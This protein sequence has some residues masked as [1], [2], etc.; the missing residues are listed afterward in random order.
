MELW[1]I[2]TIAA[3]FLQNL[4]T[5][6]QKHLQSALSTT[7][8][9]FARFGF[10][11]PFALIYLTVL[12][13]VFGKPL[14]APNSHMMVFAA[15]GGTA[16]I[17]ATFTL[18]HL[19]S[20]RN[21]AVGNAFAKTEPIQAALFSVIILG[22]S[23]SAWA[24]I[25]LIFGLFGVSVI[26]VA[27]TEL[28][29]NSFASGMTGPVARIGILSG[30]LFGVSA[31]CYR[32]ASLALGDGDFV[33]RAGLTLAFTTGFQT[34]LMLAYMRW[35]EQGQIVATLKAWPA[36]LAAGIA[37]ATASACWFTAMTIQNAAYVRALGQIELVFTLVA[38]HFVFKE[39]SNRRELIGILL[40][41]ACILLL[42]LKG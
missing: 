25:A 19:F 23:V 40:I 22:E 37:G 8:A 6:F 38:S 42:L 7:G 31:V 29:I 10:G 13:V 26:S 5:A 4:R 2:I 16:Q 34:L 20:R 41:T 27:R 11:F 1:V 14:P 33:I 3:A 32:A 15:I 30:A 28:T 12:V 35:R 39:R 17:L 9:T 36:A 21:F 24:G 18:L